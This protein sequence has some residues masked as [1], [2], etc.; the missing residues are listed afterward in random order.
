M[1]RVPSALRGAAIFAVLSLAA[2]A[3]SAAPPARAAGTAFRRVADPAGRFTIGVPADWQVMRNADASPA[4]IAVAI[5]ADDFHTNINVVVQRNVGR[6]SP[7]AYG[8]AAGRGLAAVFKGYTPVQEG[9]ARVAGRP[10]FY[11]YFTWEMND[12]SPIYQVQVY[13][14]SAAFAFAVTGTTKNDP[15]HVRRDVPLLAQIIETFRV[16]P[17]R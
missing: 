15:D 17:G 12:G 2:A 8:E 5:R 11:R 4:V 3:A 6:A 7:E 16:S 9:P 1:S 10:A 13:F 14:T